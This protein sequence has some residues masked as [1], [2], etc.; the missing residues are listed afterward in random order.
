M[1]PNNY[2]V[3]SGHLPVYLP[4]RA[5]LVALSLL[6]IF[7]LL[8][9]R[10]PAQNTGEDFNAMKGWKLPETAVPAT[11]LIEVEGTLMQG[12]QRFSGWLFERYPNGQLL[13]AAKYWLGLQNGLGLLWYP[14]GT[15]QMSANY[16]R[17]ALHG[18]FLGWYANGNVIY[19]M[20]INRGT[21]ASDNLSDADDGRQSSE[22]EVS[23]G[24]GRDNDNTPE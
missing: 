13:R 15:P 17:G 10:L 2:D 20:Y 18:R 6:F 19:D 24:E 4:A 8:P 1:C 5:L 22:T 23:E 11:E 3:I 21:Y 7:V 16:Q 14:D 9:G 12:E